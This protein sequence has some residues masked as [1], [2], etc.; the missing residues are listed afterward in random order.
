[1][2]EADTKKLKR[3]KSIKFGDMKLAQCEEVRNLILDAVKSENRNVTNEG[4]IA[5]ERYISAVA[6]ENRARMGFKFELAILDARIVGVIEI[7]E[8][9]RISMLYVH[10]DYTRLG[11]GSRLVFRAAS[12]CAASKLMT[13]AADEDIGFYE[14]VG[15]V[16]CGDRSVV[17]GIP[18]TPYKLSMSPRDKKPPSKLRSS[19]VALFVFSGTGNTL[20]VAREVGRAL[21]DEGRDVHLYD[22]KAENGEILTK[23]DDD[24]A[25][26]LA[27]PV[28]CFSTYPAVWRFVESMPFGH[29][30]EVFALSTCGGFSGGMQG[31]LG[32]V[33]SK[34]G[35]RLL[36][37]KFFIMPGNYGNKAIPAE[38]N[39]HRVEKAL[40][41]S[42]AF[43]SDIL[44]GTAS[45]GGYPWGARFTHWLAQTRTPW[46]FFY[47]MFPIL[48]DKTKCTRCYLCER[49]CPAYAITKD[50]DGYPFVEPRVCESCQ[51]CVG[52]CPSSALGNPK[53][54]AV[55]YRAMDYDEF[56]ITESKN[57]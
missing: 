2:T 32:E 37:A 13:Y 31:A 57:R 50:G 4:R 25:V 21:R 23:L 20:L 16:R 44:A 28:A 15:F 7:R 42:R 24:A 34:K 41:D 22:M 26:G 29:G 56:K 18:S 12:R 3:A 10:P 35:Y 33:L 38:K 19:S 52:F 45:W 48:T 11:I 51:R 55:Q 14:R 40:Q 30:R 47:R 27:F 1:M 5:F 46:N 54:P 8:V 36:S 9:D 49:I 53:K 43:V 6:I 39:A 17:L